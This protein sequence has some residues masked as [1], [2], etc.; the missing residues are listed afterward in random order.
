MNDILERLDKLKTHIQED[1]FLEGNGLSNEV[2]IHIFCYDQIG[3]A[4]V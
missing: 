4:H 2:P 1:N 3:R